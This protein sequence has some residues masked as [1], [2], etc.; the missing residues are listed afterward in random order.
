VNRQMCRCG[1]H[2]SP[3]A[4]LLGN[5]IE[6]QDK[7]RWPASVQLPTVGVLHFKLDFG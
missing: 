2:A 4:L 7:K 3:V 5:R 1:Q 6:S